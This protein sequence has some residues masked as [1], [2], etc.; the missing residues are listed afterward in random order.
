M[1]EER[2]TL[3]VVAVSVLLWLLLLLAAPALFK[4]FVWYLEWWNLWRG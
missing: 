4:V 2:E 3:A 1:A